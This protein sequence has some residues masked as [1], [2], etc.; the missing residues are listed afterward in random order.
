MLLNGLGATATAL[1]VLMVLIAKIAERA[2]ITLLLIPAL[3]A[4]MGAVH[5]HYQ[6]VG[7]E[8]ASTEPLKVIDVR[9]P[10][11]VV[12]IDR[13][14]RISRHALRY[15]LSVSQEVIALHIEC[16]EHS[17]ELCREWGKLVEEPLLE[18][19]VPPPGLVVLDSP[20]RFV[21]NP[22]LDYVLDLAHANASRLIAVLIPE[23]VGRHWY[24]NVLH[25][26]RAALLKGLLY[27]KG[28]ERITVIN[29]PWYLKC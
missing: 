5:R 15:A 25:N 7:A 18:F 10:I 6:R 3:L 4:F 21:V 20:Y 9:P 19:G 24:A 29:V 12:P 14:S 1:T 13:W 8:I 2:W 17:G 27:L 22:I 28:T 26:Q 23:M 11:V 16:G